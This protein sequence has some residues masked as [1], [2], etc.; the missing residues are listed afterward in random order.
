MPM[1]LSPPLARLLEDRAFV[2]LHP[3]Y[4]GYES[5]GPFDEYCRVAWREPSGAIAKTRWSPCSLAWAV[6]R[7]CLELQGEAE[8]E[9]G[10]ELARMA[11]FTDEERSAVRA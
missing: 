3:R 1:T 2:S 9:A 4:L 11:A 7:T 5:S 8:Q 6:A 10:L